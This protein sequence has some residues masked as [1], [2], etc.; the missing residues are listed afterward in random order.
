MRRGE[1]IDYF[2]ALLRDLADRTGGPMY[3]T[4]GGL[5]RAC[6]RAGL[7]FF[8][9]NGELRTTGEPRVVRVGTHGLTATGK[10]TLWGRLRQHRGSLA[11]LPRRSSGVALA[12]PSPERSA[13]RN[14][15]AACASSS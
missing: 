13:D 14:S 6:P 2:Y 4:D 9:E 5:A 1:A 10:A 15:L 3:L 8:F 7:Y 12:A 11:T